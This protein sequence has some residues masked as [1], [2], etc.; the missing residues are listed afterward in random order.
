MGT[1]IIVDDDRSS[2]SLL[3]M[4]LE[5]DGFEVHI[6]P[7]TGAAVEQ[8]KLGVDAFIVDIYLAQGEEGLDLLRS[9]RNGDTPA[10]PSCPVIITSGDSRRHNDAMA[11]GATEFL[12]KPFS[13]NALSDSLRQL[14]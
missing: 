13:P 1:L 6:C 10:A 9:I 14:L 8:A 7:S 2:S 11:A 4:L 3:K 12:L 5:M